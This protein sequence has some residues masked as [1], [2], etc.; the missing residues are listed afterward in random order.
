MSADTPAATM[1][2]GELKDRGQALTGTEP[3]APISSPSTRGGASTPASAALRVQMLT[4]AAFAG[5]RPG[6][7]RMQGRWG[8]GV[9]QNLHLPQPLPDR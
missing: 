3:P 4:P 6:L 8:T 7:S 9:G 5:P 2:A 1:F